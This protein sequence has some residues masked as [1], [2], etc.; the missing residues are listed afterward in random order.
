MATSYD[1]VVAALRA[2]LADNKRLKQRNA[3]PA[4]PPAPEPIAIVS[5]GC[6]LPGGIR[7]PEQLWDL[8]TDGR[9]AIGEFPPDRGW[10]LGALS[11][12]STAGAG[13]FLYEAGDFDPGFFGISPREAIA[14]DPQQRLLLET[15]WE[16]FER[17]GIDR[18]TARG[19]RTG[20]FAG[21]NNQDYTG[22]L[23]AALAQG[24]DGHLGT[25][26]SAS[27]VSGRISYTFG[28]EGPA[29]TVDTA[30][31]SS[32]VAVHLAAQSLRDGECSL[33]LAGGVAVMATPSVFVEFSRQGG[34]ATNG[35]C[36]SFAAAADGTGWGEGAAMV[37]LERL[38]DARRNGH[39]VLAVLRGSAV[40]Q[41]GAS[42]GLT[43]PNGPAQ[44]RVIRT[45]LANARLT[46]ADVDVVEAHGTGTRLGDP[47]E[48]QALL[49]TYGQDRP[50]DQ[51]VWLGSIKSNIG[52]TQAAAGVTGIIKM[53]Q[54]M[55]HGVLPATLHVD[56]PTPQVDWSAG[57][58]ELLTS[59]RP[60]PTTGRPRRAAVSSFGVSGTN[61]HVIL[62]Q[63]TEAEDRIATPGTRAAHDVLAW[64]VSAREPAGLRAQAAQ[65][66]DH[67]REHPGLDPADVAGSL[68][69][70]RSHF[71][72]R[73]VAVGT[74]TDSLTA[75]LARIADGTDPGD[76]A[77]ARPQ[78]AFVFSGQGAQRAGTGRDLYATFPVYA[79]AFDAV[80]AE[81][82]VHLDRS[83]REVILDDEAALERTGYAQAALF[84]VE[85]A[86]YRLVTSFGVVPDQLIGHS[87]G[88]IA[89]AHVAGVLSLPDAAALVAARGRLIQAL[90]AGGVMVA[91]RATESEVREALAGHEAV[92]SVAAVNGPKSVVVAGA[93]EAVEQVVARFG[94]TR[95]LDVGHAL[96]SPLMAPMTADFAQAI[97]GLTHAPARIPVISTV[98][99]DVA[100]FGT[101]YWVDQ[102]RATVR[103]A[104]GIRA[105]HE[106]GVS[107]YLE[108]GP[109]AVLTPLGADC[110]EGA[111]RD[112]AP[113]FVAAQSRDGVEALVT[114]L[115]RLHC[116]GVRLDWAALLPGT[117]RVDL[118]TYPFQRQHY[119]PALE[120]VAMPTAA[121][122]AEQPPAVSSAPVLSRDSAFEEV[123]D[124]IRQETAEMLGYSGIESIRP[125]RDFLELGVD[126]VIAQE[127][128]HRLS[129]AT[130]LTLAP[131]LLFAHQD[132]DRL[133]R[134]L[135]AEM[136]GTTAAS[137]APTLD[138]MFRQARHRDDLH[139]FTTLLMRLAGYRPS[140]TA[141]DVDE[142]RVAVP[143]LARLAEDG[144]GPR[145]IAC[146]TTSLMA[147]PQEY[148]RL[149]GALRGRYQIS[150]LVNPGYQED[151][152][153]PA[154]LAA[155]LRL[156][157]RAIRADV[158][159]EPFIL[160]GHS[161]GG[162][163]ANA[164]AAELE[165]EGVG[166]AAVVL[167]DSYPPADAVL[168]RW[169][170]EL[171]DGLDLDDAG[172]ADQR[173]LAW[174]SYVRHYGDFEP[175]PTSA[176]TLLVR[177]GEPLGTVPDD[178]DW[179]P[180]WQ[181][182][183]TVAD[184][185]GDHFTMVG[186]QVD[187]TAQTVHDWL[188][189]TL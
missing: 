161:A 61:A 177:A 162:L 155:A 166:P 42:S 129:A 179:R 99:G 113:L 72:Y 63:P 131:G 123:R 6:R 108:I 37:L 145:I 98:T 15:A 168:G 16:T 18:A 23:V 80:C 112:N 50:A 19:S 74:G 142:G 89:A 184:A 135:M 185:T 110:V 84:A 159:A 140:F 165:A 44:Q 125:G 55:R 104:D 45:A 169:I 54:A 70:T 167:L 186:D 103:F 52:H 188:T 127:I 151:E 68:A 118:P 94:K 171:L 121:A 46:A 101:D 47:I 5:M 158:G 174:A 180:S 153:A 85:V 20:V 141:A 150:A 73:A 17:A 128:R 172:V 124:L 4:A 130:G 97:G 56:R 3:V 164:L 148:A 9:D 143:A 160:L 81:L 39:P 133:A 106:R 33:A 57:A 25:G 13:A 92:V 30:C 26:N 126:S 35:R 91:V 79:E 12:L 149:A 136:A 71:E 144:G 34:L 75:A 176:P 77:T 11:E 49:A 147:G 96:H 41:D 146:C 32:L 182:P 14:M 152:P 60:W 156:Q 22:V 1:E 82:D 120:P 53:V 187:R 183:H 24:F 111:D 116:R 107:A 86:L 59:A 178:R 78:V 102:I 83:I 157:V 95:T 132:P 90:P 139:E 137:P 93:A 138:V 2:A 119:W 76:L 36:K 122:P 48:A 27:V 88:E 65:L 51:P 31:S 170:P 66:L 175:L 69:V 114:A 163:V 189:A 8:V 7:G 38:S 173:Y 109:D 10:D 29:L 115:A 64:P 21:T 154:D 28:L 87:T 181:H 67:L 105:L 43:A 40:N 117:T 134:H 100:E 58:V 62:E